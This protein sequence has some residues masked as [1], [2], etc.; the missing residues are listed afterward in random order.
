MRAPSS[1]GF[2]V[3]GLAALVATALACFSLRRIG[4]LVAA[5]LPRRAVTGAVTLPSVLLVVAARDE[6]DCVDS[7]LAALEAIDY[8]AERLFTVLVDDCST[9]QT[10]DRF[11]QW[12]ARRPRALSLRLPTHAG[13]HQA[14]REGMTAEAGE[15][16]VTCDAD[17]RPRPDCLR[18]LTEAFADEGVGAAAAFVAP[19][20]ATATPIARYAAV[21]SWV[22]QL[23]TSAGKDRLDLNPPAPGG[24]SAYRRSAL[25]QIGWFGPEPGADV[26][27]TAALT[28]AGWRTRFVP[29]AVAET[30]VVQRWRDYWHQ[31]IRWGRNLFSSA[32][33]GERVSRSVPLAR[34]VEAWMT[35]AGYAD[36]LVLLLALPLIAARRLTSRFAALYL[37]IV[38]GEVCVALAKARVA[39]DGHRFLL[40]T[41][42]LFALDVVASVAAAAA[43]LL[44][45]PRAW[46]PQ[47]GAGSDATS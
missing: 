31:H 3:K 34:R 23:V 47:R 14:Q 11:D 9:D 20:N 29:E 27:V 7:L 40:W 42:A 26:R 5:L 10:G 33:A 21:E 2:L 44:G 39:R 35:A 28:R 30:A 43:H 19:E 8:P 36:R 45:R 1:T 12:A 32:G 46:R 18:R 41:G 38:T 17:V 22:H 6:A 15:I 25:E 4:L 13:K 37:A 24:C 16:I